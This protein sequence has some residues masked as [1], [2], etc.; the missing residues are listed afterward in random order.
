LDITPLA[1]YYSLEALFQIYS[2]LQ[3]AKQLIGQNVQSN[4][5]LDELCIKLMN[6]K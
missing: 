5:V 1:E 6:V 2:D 3:H 4:L